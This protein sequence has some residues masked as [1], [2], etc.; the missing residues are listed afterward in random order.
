MKR[1]K[2][3]PT[4]NPV[5]RVRCDPDDQIQVARLSAA[6]A[7][8]TLPAEPDALPVDHSGRNVHIERALSIRAGDGKTALGSVVGLLDG[9]LGLELL[10]RTRHRTSC[11][12]A[13]ATKYSAEKVLKIDVPFNVGEPYATRPGV[14]S[15]PR[16]AR[17]GPRT[18]ARV[19]L[20]P[21]PLLG[22]NV[23]RYAAEVL[24]ECVVP[25]ALLRIGEHVIC[26]GDLLE[27]SLGRGVLVDVRVVLPSQFAVGPLDLGLVGIFSDTEDFVEVPSHQLLL[28]ATTTAAGRRI[29]SSG[30][31]P[32]RTTWATVPGTSSMFA[33]VPTASWRAGSKTLPVSSRRGKPRSASTESACWYTARTP[34]M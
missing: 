20:R 6:G 25:L 4:G 14:S 7:P 22:A 9:D 11:C 30:P 31:Y 32:G 29:S 12:A 17:T 26:L 5:A 8:A 10:I 16:A 2:E 27:S 23:G 13:T 15:R 19:R 24:S 33:M 3:I 1:R 34:S 21:L 18:G 28:V